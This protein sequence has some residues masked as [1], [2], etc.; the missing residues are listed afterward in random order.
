MRESNRQTGNALKRSNALTGNALRTSNASTGAALCISN[1]IT[2]ESLR[3]SNDLTSRALRNEALPFD[4]TAQAL[5][6]ERHDAL[7]VR[8]KRYQA[9][10]RGDESQTLDKI[11]AAADA[12]R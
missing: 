6:K 2:G 5:L 9:R 3:M 1:I 10:L 8:L 11:D 12:V 7:Q 4:R